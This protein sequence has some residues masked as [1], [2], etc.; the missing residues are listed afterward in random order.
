MILGSLTT[1]DPGNIFKTIEDCKKDNVMGMAWHGMALHSMPGAGDSR[2]VLCN[3]VSIIGLAAGIKVCETICKSTHGTY[4]VVLDEQH[5][6]D[7]LMAHITPPPVAPQMETA[8]M[9]VAFPRRE[10]PQSLAPCAWC[11]HIPHAHAHAHALRLRLRL[12]LAAH[13]LNRACGPP[14]LPSA[15]TARSAA[16]AT[17]VRGAGSSTATSRPSAACA[18]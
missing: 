15:T 3:A 11:V 2:R 18:G 6:G 17:C 16:G 14:S 5:F 4:R 12:R 7:L 8:L 10:N 13:A 1:S 9:P